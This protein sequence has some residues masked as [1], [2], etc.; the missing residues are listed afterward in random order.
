M[1][2]DRRD[3]WDTFDFNQWGASAEPAHDGVSHPSESE[4]TE[5]RSHGTWANEGGRIF[6]EESDEAAG[7]DERDAHAE[8]GSAWA[9]D[10]IEIPL[11][12]PDNARVR[13]TR[14]WLLRRRE[15]E[16]S[17]VGD[18]LLSQRDAADESAEID[19]I[20]FSLLA[21]LAAISEYDQLLEVLDRIRS[22]SGPH[23]VLIEF[24]LALTDRLAELATAPEAPQ[25]VRNNPLLVPADDDTATSPDPQP[26][27]AR[28]IAEWEGR[29]EVVVLARRRIEQV[30]APE[31]ED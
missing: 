17:E 13:A 31:P 14:A 9:A 10:D 26:P 6:W 18:L 15:L 5:R 3:E 2:D 11:G 27:S 23:S 16:A 25:D 22:H 19:D 7:Q 1:S 20:R 24:Y 28:S 21:R 29:Y 8:A 4:E 30:S 12:A